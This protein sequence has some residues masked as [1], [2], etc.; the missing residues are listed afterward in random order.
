MAQFT[1]HKEEM[2]FLNNFNIDRIFNVIER[3]DYLFLYYIKYCGGQSEQEKRVYLSALA[4]A[5]NIEI[6]EISKAVENLQNKGYVSWKTDREMGKTYVELTSKAVELM[7]D[8]RKRM[9]NSYKQIQEEIGEEEL[10]RTVQT[11]GKIAGILKRGN[12]GIKD[13]E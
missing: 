1:E 11:M 10:E 8:E 9:E 12:T 2:F 5:M 3:T 13:A 6:P 4:D 7:Y